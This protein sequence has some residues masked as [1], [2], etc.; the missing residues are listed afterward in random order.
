MDM[1]HLKLKGISKLSTITESG[2]CPNCPGTDLCWGTGFVENLLR[3][4]NIQDIKSEVSA[5]LFAE[6]MSYYVS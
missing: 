1:H 5:K 6:I 2:A 4:P 3:F